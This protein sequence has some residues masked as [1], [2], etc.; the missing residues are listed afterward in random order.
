MRA[1]I[2]AAGRGERM[3]PLTD[4][5]PKPLLSVGGKPLIVHHIEKLARAGIRSI[6]INHA[7]LG[8]K[9]VSALG[10]GQQWGVEIRWSDESDGGLETAGG[11]RHALPLL[12]NEPFLVVNGDIWLACDYDAFVSRSLDA[13]QLG[14]LWLVDN[15]PQHPRGDFSLQGDRVV[16]LPGLTFCG[17]AL[18]RPEAF[19]DM[20]EGKAPLRPC[21]E[22][23]MAAGQLS[24]SH[25]T[26]EWHDI[27]TP[28]RLAWLDAQLLQVSL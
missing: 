11:I 8:D 2:L 25:L 27:G 5:L 1:M 23:W 28:E 13:G 12:G 9:L 3:R 26:C 17:V 22:R 6:V 15:P 19:A 21:F 24:G 18:Y 4:R 7:W 14:H 10:D 20:P 16:D